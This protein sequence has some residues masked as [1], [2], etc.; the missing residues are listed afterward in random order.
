LHDLKG[1]IDTLLKEQEPTMIVIPESVCLCE[2]DSIS[3]QKAALFHCGERMRNRIA[4]LDISDDDKD[5]QDPAGDPVSRFRSALGN[6]Y[7]DFA[8]AYYPWLNTEIVDISDQ[9]YR[10]IMNPELLK[11]LV[12][13]ELDQQHAEIPE[14]QVNVENSD[15]SSVS[16]NATPSI[17]SNKYIGEQQALARIRIEKQKA[18]VKDIFSVRVGSRETMTPEDIRNGIL[19][20]TVLV[21]ITRPAEFIEITFQQQ[22]Q[23]A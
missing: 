17:S 6:D 18:V 5:R 14:A 23:T 8:T 9:Y 4:I 21:A 1:G 10:N 11:T 20:I 3:L 16:G 13:D 15:Q 22:V 19:R 12:S 7:L 2:A